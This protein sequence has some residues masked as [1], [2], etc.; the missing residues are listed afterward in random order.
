MK[1][2]QF[3]RNKNLLPLI[4]ALA[5]AAVVAAYYIFSGRGSYDLNLRELSQQQKVEKVESDGTQ[6]INITCKN[7]RNYQITFNE[8]HSNYDD[9]IFNACGREGTQ[10]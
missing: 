3:I 6:K 5:I 7:G 10:E 1:Y 4:A 8:S 9:L 2:L